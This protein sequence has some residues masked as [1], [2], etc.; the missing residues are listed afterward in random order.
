MVLGK[1][2]DMLTPGRKDKGS[3]SSR[4]ISKVSRFDEETEENKSPMNTRR[5][6]K[7]LDM[8]STEDIPDVDSSPRRN[9]ARETRSR[10]TDKRRPENSRENRRSSPGNIN[11]DR[12]LQ[13]PSNNPPRRNGRNSNRTTN[14]G[15]SEK[16]MLQEIMRKLEDIDRK[17]DRRR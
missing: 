15:R 7:D 3:G 17:L 2:K 11:R 4:S 16:E 1:I 13:R 12:N 14:P 10:N 5:R 8:P 9:K 6:R